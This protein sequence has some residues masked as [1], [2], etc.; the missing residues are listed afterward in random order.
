MKEEEQLLSQWLEIGFWIIIVPVMK[1]KKNQNTK[2]RQLPCLNLSKKLWLPSFLSKITNGFF[3]EEKSHNQ[4]NL[5]Y[6]ELVR[7]E[8]QI[9]SCG[10]IIFP[11]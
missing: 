3:L 5:Y 10:H 11:D 4:D 2:T 8:T 7:M 9:N 1:K 6:M